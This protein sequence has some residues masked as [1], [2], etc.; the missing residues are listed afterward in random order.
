MP[1]PASKSKSVS[2]VRLST[3]TNSTNAPR[4]TP[5][6]TY[7][8]PIRIRR[9]N[10]SS[11]FSPRFIHGLYNLLFQL[12]QKGLIFLHAH[13]RI[14]VQRLF[15]VLQCIG[16]SAIV[17]TYGLEGFIVVEKYFDRF[18]TVGESITNSQKTLLDDGHL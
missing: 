6:N 15:P 13:R 11:F 1:V 2:G 9:P 12:S 16:T 14:F 5:S 7:S 18:H 8:T 10:L 3:G 17:F 4:D